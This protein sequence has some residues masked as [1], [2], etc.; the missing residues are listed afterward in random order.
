MPM[1]LSNWQMVVLIP[2]HRMFHSYYESVNHPIFTPVRI[3]W[4]FRK[5]FL[6]I[7]LETPSPLFF[8]VLCH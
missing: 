8:L 5:F 4:T 1:I 6:I 7:N 2:L 3:I